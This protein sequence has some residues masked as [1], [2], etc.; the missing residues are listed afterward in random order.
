MCIQSYMHIICK[1]SV[2]F[3]DFLIQIFLS[4]NDNKKTLF[5]KCVV[6]LHNGICGHHYKGKTSKE[7]ALCNN[8]YKIY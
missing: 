1:Y 2:F 7:I 8:S 3:Y 6:R 4:K 5:D